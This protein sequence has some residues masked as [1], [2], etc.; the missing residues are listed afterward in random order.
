MSIFYLSS[1]FLFRTFIGVG[2]AILAFASSSVLSASGSEMA[3]SIKLTVPVEKDSIFTPVPTFLW[4]EVV[5]AEGYRVEIST[6][7]NFTEIID[8]D[9][10]VIPH[11]VP[12]F[13]LPKGTY[14]WR[15]IGLAED[16]SVI[17]TSDHKHFSVEVPANQYEISADAGSADIER[18]FADAAAHTPA[19]V[20]FAEGAVYRLVPEFHD[21]VRLQGVS[22]L[23][24]DGRGA[25][26]I[27]LEPAS[28][29][30]RL[31]DCSRVTVMNLTVRFDPLPFSIGTIKK[32]DSETGDFELIT[33]QP[34]LMAFDDPVLAQHWTW[35]VALDRDRPGRMANDT[36]LVVSTK[37]GQVSKSIGRD[38]DEIY[39]LQLKSPRV[40]K[41][42][43]PGD[44]YIVFARRNGRGLVR[45]EGGEDVSFVNVTN[46]G[47][48]A[49]HYTAF[50]SSGLKVIG[51]SS[52][53]PKGRWF[54]GNADGL[55][56]RSNQL[57]PWVEGCEFEG[58][59]DD[60]VAIY[61]KGLFILKQ[62]S[63]TKLR[64]DSELFNLETGQ[65]IRI[66]NPRDGLVVVDDVR[67]VAVEAQPLG[68]GGIQREH[69]LV[70][71]EEPLDVPLETSHSDSLQNDQIFNGT[72]V[73]RWF[74]VRNNSFRRIR[75]FGTVVRALGGVIEGNRYDEISNIPIVLRN[76]PDGWRNGLNSEDIF[77]LNNTIA[78]SG[79]VNGR[80]EKGQ[81]N[82]VMYR[83][84]RALAE[85][86]EHR[87][88]VIEGNHIQNWQERG[89][90]V[91]NAVDVRILGNRLTSDLPSFDN[92]RA[93]YGI[94]VD[95]AEDVWI[96]DNVIEDHR[97]LDADIWVGDNAD[98]VL[99]ER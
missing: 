4:E 96:F 41:Y 36:P 68:A 57:G 66:F 65:S 98:N 40:S 84:G 75:R 2:L 32:V 8:E 95:N 77:I 26:I 85:G 67:V 94:Y 62:E 97:P 20:R 31:V 11:Y 5:E 71:L 88:I 29:L 30:V 80:E 10:L 38:G 70:T 22:D 61:S 78:V 21:L 27:F 6:N 64:V 33:D 25:E 91:Q 89:I 9:E 35:G 73:N 44:K 24:V 43:M 13:P 54:G 3:P 69:F 76:E 37:E 92:E 53:I 90:S 34:D 60:A 15:V 17:A 72:M 48:S 87:K 45:V 49:G 46:Y 52:L 19:I 99:I 59:G 7:V 82:V 14:F 93:H 39:T 58:L 51:C 56:V 1:Y 16:G 28:G 12:D 83:M 74:A 50:D 63:D 18:I 47:A 42:L 81:I 79:Y 23:V 55:H 86:R